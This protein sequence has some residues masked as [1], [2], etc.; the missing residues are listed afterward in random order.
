M[1][2]MKI[3]KERLLIAGANGLLGQKLLHTFR[4]DY[5]I[6]ATGIEDKA[7]VQGA[8]FRYIR[9]DLTQ[10]TEVHNLV[11]AFEPTGVLNAAAYTNVDGSET[12]RENCWKVNVTAVEYLAA[13]AKKVGAKLV[14]VSTDYVFDG[15]SGPYNENSRPNPLGYYGK[16]KLAGENAVIASGVDYAICRTMVLYGV[17]IGLRPNF[18]TWLADMLSQGRPVNIVDD[19][20]GHPTISDDL[21]GA[22]R[23]VFE[24]KKSGI[25][26]TTGADYVSR[27]DFAIKMAQVFG[28]DA[29]R[30]NRSKTADLNQKAPR[31]LESEFILDK[32]K[33]ETGY[34]PMSLEASLTLLREQLSS[35]G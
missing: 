7:F 4:G 16:S 8:F 34:L 15:N 10:R 30:I 17:G 29:S 21:A 12:D 23:A 20:L 26:H 3:L 24:S 25:F 2:K 33:K 31:P 9:A 6:L 13:A 27:Y 32:L 19:Q 1:E 14:H 22:M 18:A 5:D 28:F 35:K 11:R